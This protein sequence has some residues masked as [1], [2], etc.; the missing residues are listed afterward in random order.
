MS[1]YEKTLAAMREAQRFLDRC[2][3][4]LERHATDPHMSRSFDGGGSSKEMGAVKRVSMDLSRALTE[5]R[6]P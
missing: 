4:L 6:K 5:L 3:D 2:E 1:R